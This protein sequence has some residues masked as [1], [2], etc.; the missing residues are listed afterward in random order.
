[1]G[2]NDVGAPKILIIMGYMTYMSTKYE[3]HKKDMML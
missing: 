1:M 2:A 3:H